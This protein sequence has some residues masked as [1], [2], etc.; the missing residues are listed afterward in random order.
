MLDEVVIHVGVVVAPFVNIILILFPIQNT[1]LLF[2]I[3]TVES[4]RTFFIH[5]GLLFSLK[6]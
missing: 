2:S 1:F 3:N 6:I 4:A 5:E